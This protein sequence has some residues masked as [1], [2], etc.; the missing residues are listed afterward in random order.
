MD[1]RRAGSQASLKGP[2]DW[3]TGTVR[4]DPLFPIREPARSAG[5][6]VTFAPEARTA[7][8]RGGRPRQPVYIYAFTDVV[9]QAAIRISIDGKGAWR[10]NVSIERQ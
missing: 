10:D 7:W 5:N 6:A 3:F 9:K 8:H 4:V 1:I 2:E